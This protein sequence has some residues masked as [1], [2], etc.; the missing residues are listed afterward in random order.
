MLIM[1]IIDN[2]MQRLQALATKQSGRVF[3]AL[4]G[5]PGS[6][7]STMAARLAS[8]VNTAM[9]PGTMVALGMDGFHLTKAQLRRMH[10]PEAALARRGA[11]WTFDVPALAVRLERLRVADGRE[12]VPWPGFE[13]GV[14]DPVEG[15][16]SIAPET[17]F[18]LVEGLYLLCREDGWGA[19]SGFFDERWFLNTPLD[20]ALARLSRR[21]QET[22]KLTAEAA[23]ARIAANDRLNAEIVQR[24]RPFADRLL[25]E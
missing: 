20:I 12:A 8:E 9:G 17:R 5:L 2:P 24:S 19:V 3:V 23:D 4:A 1:P 22:W 13:H 21:H 14:G 25:M 18:V 7:K 10:D 6:G 15:A 16:F 11:P